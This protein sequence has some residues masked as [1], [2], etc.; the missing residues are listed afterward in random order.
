MPRFADAVHHAVRTDSYDTVDIPEFYALV[1]K[2][3]FCVG[4][5]RL[6]DVASKMGV[7]HPGGANLVAKIGGPDDLIRSLFDL[8][9][10]EKIRTIFVA[11]KIYD[12]IL[13]SPKCTS[14]REKHGVA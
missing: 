5:H 2:T 3:P 6:D 13:V 7:L 12:V 11:G 1:T 10:F 8:F 14:D 9:A 4:D